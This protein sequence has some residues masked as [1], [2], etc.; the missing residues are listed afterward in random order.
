M[1]R[2]IL[3]GS[4]CL[5]MMATSCSDML[6][7]APLDKVTPESYFTQSNQL[8][9]YAIK[10][11]NF[12]ALGGGYTDYVGIDNGTDVQISASVN[13]RWVPGEWRTPATGS[14]WTFDRIRA[15]NYFLE[16]VL[17]KY[18]AGSISGTKTDIEH[19]IGEEVI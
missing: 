12:P 6:D 2:N 11:Y 13:T 19:Y 8:G 1:K 3:L 15:F 7:M 5:V 17:P 4:I 9:D 10:Y 16:Q 18:E 14:T